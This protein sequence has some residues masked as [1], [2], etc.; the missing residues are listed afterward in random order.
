MS[1][2]PKTAIV[3]LNWN[4]KKL[5]E[6]FLP[7]VI[8][9][10]PAE[11]K[12][13]VA[14]NASEDDSI[15]FLQT[16][17]PLIEVIAMKENKGY[18]GGYNEALAQI[19]ASYYVLLNSDVEVTENWL[20]PLVEMMDADDQLA[21]CQPVIRQYRNKQYFEYAGASGGFIDSFGYPFCRGRIFDLE[22][23]DKGQY[24][25][26]IDIFWATG[27]CMMV[28]ADIFQLVGG[29]DEDFFAHMEEIDLCWRMQ[30][31][32][33]RLSVNTHSVVYHVGGA[34]LPKD[35]PKKAFLNYRNNLLM[36]AKNLAFS[37]LF[38]R[39]FIRLILDGISAIYFLMK[40]SPS[41]FTSIFKAHMAFWGSMRSITAK[42]RQI[43]NKKPMRSLKGVYKGSI[44]FA[45]F[46]RGKRS[47][48]ELEF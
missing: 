38:Y 42:R 22:E 15:S 48:S 34:S 5:L 18:A 30:N 29:L 32:G 33:Y 16:N 12:I 35:N 10:C 45:Y 36:M 47:F 46:V 31:M 26:N 11:T 14:D 37:E 9:N 1:V 4:G 27:A 21:A 23:E 3:I 44:V 24:A 39:I 19:E 13:Y 25:E 17:Y 8:A 20:Q 43:K 2:K 40:G 41:T 7:S 6:D 28:R